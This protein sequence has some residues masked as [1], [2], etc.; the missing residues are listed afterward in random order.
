LFL[1]VSEVCPPIA[2]H[3]TLHTASF[4][5][6]IISY[7]IH[8]LPD[9]AASKHGHYLFD[10]LIGCWALLLIWAGDPYPLATE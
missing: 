7:C 8:E 3:Y 1:A 2:I 4:F 9:T 6:S 5:A 10:I